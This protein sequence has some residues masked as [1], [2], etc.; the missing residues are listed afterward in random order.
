M[1]LP[2]SEYKNVRT[3]KIQIIVMVILSWFTSCSGKKEKQREKGLR[4]IQEENDRLRNEIKSLQ[5]CKE[6]VH[7]EL[8]RVRDEYKGLSEKYT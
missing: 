4:R 8:C 3:M 5:T 1:S 6:K 7:R 2:L